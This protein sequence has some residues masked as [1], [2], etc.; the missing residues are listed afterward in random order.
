MARGL[1]WLSR[2]MGWLSVRYP[3]YSL[4]DRLAELRALDLALP[5]GTH[6][7]FNEYFVPYV[8]ADEDHHAAYALGCITEF[9]RGPQLQFLK[10]LAQGRLSEMGGPTFVDMDHLVRLLDFGRATQEILDRMPLTSR[11][12][13]TSFTE[14]LNKVQAQ[15]PR[16]LDEKLLGIQPERYTPLDILLFGRLAGADVNWPIYFSLIEHRLSGDFIEWW[17]RLRRAGAGVSTSFESPGKAGQSEQGVAQQLGDFLNSISRSGSNSIVVHGKRTLSGKPL[18]VNDPH[19]GQHLPNVW[20][21]VGLN[22]PSFKCVGLMFP[23]V[24]VFGL[25][26]NPALAWGGTNL[27]AASSDLVRLSDATVQNATEQIIKIRVRFSWARKRTLR[28]C[29]HGPILTDCAALGRLCGK[30]QLA[31]RWAGHWPT[32]EITSFLS[33]MKASNVAELHQ[34]MHGVGVTPLNVLGADVQGNIGHVLA[35]TL[36]WRPGFPE[37]DWVLPENTASEHWARQ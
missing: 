15:R 28:F 17:N 24:P 20:M 34:A 6:I 14:G 32:D 11:Q 26:R 27:R 37:D 29:A 10:R 36:P 2:N 7:R 30:D 3:V 12:W 13:I 1:A 22:T 33:A 16:G 31:L 4:E 23:G 35:T 21:M 25:G 8:F 5:E 19:L 9:Q 18:L